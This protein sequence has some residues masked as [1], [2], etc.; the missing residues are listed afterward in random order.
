MWTQKRL[1]QG[2]NK[3][4]L[5]KYG[6]EQILAVAGMQN[7]ETG[8]KTLARQISTKVRRGAMCSPSRK[9]EKRDIL[10]TG[11]FVEQEKG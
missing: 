7:Q 8:R 5:W 2:I 4:G 10:S 11:L 6:V 1:R 3:M 9:P